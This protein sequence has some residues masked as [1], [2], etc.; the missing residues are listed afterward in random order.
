M[1]RW[2][3]HRV[4]RYCKVLSTI[5]R[6]DLK[7]AFT[8][9]RAW[10]LKTQLKKKTRSGK[11]SYFRDAIVFERPHFQN[12]KACVFN[13]FPVNSVVKK[14]R[15]R[16]GLGWMVKIAFWNS[17]AFSESFAMIADPCA[18][19]LYSLSSLSASEFRLGT[20]SA[21]TASARHVGDS[22]TQLKQTSENLTFFKNRI[23]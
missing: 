7:T 19:S 1:E 22:T 21:S 13:F 6:R 14:L 11:S 16:S 12:R 23:Y 15:F 9:R 17:Y 3:L 4:Y 18:R 5:Q 20:C 2:E 8:L 10:N